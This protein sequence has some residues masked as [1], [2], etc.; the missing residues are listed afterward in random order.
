MYRKRLRDV[1]G[2]EV[3]FEKFNFCNITCLSLLKIGAC[4]QSR[5]FTFMG[6]SR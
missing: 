4:F 2:T 1:P 3:K 6:T 5:Y